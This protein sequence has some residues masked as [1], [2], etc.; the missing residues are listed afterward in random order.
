M[1]LTIVVHG[2]PAPQGSKRAFVNKHTGRAALV[3]SSKKVQPWRQAV[4]G[5]AVDDE[6]RAEIVEHLLEIW[7]E[8]WPDTAVT[9]P[10]APIAAELVRL[11]AG[12]VTL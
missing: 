4:V 2:Q 5:R 7:Y 8:A 9:S 1:I 3:E 11:L 10:H 12:P 6:T